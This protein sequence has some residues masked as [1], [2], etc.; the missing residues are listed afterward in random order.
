MSLTDSSVPLEIHRRSSLTARGEGLEIHWSSGD[1]VFLDSA[2]LRTE[3]PCAECAEKRGELQHDK[4]LA[5]QKTKAR[6]GL[7]VIKASLD[8]ET[9]LKQVWPV[10]NY[11]IGIRWGDK[12]DSGIYS[13][14]Q[15]RELVRRITN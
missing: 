15:L 5:V 8:E 12:H 7:N 3:C 11:A 2:L 10:G 14:Q 9:D 6:T 1:N 13:Y 4:P